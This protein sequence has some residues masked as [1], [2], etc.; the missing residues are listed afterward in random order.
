MKDYAEILNPARLSNGRAID[1]ALQVIEQDLTQ[2]NS[3]SIIEQILASGRARSIALLLSGVK[4]SAQLSSWILDDFPSNTSDYGGS[5]AAKL[6]SSLSEFSTFHLLLPDHREIALRLGAHYEEVTAASLAMQ[7]LATRELD[8]MKHQVTRQAPRIARSEKLC[9][10]FSDEE[11]ILRALMDLEISAPTHKSEV[12][13]VLA[14][15]L[16]RQKHSLRYYLE[17]LQVPQI[18]REIRTGIIQDSQQMQLP[19]PPNPPALSLV[20]DDGQETP[21][22]RLASEHTLER[23][24]KQVQLYEAIEGFGCWP[25]MISTRTSNDLREAR[26]RDRKNFLILLKKIRDLSRGDFSGDNQRRIN[27]AGDIIPVFEARATFK[28]RLIYQ[29][30]CRPETVTEERQVIRIFGVYTPAELNV[31]LWDAVGRQLAR[32]GKGYKDR[33]TYRRKL[34]SDSRLFVPATFPPLADKPVVESP[35]L[36][37]LHVPDDSDLQTILILQ[38]FVPFSRAL[39]NTIYADLDAIFPFEVS[40]EEKSIIEYPFS[41]YVLGRSGTGKTTAMLYKM[42]WVERS[43]QM[44]SEGMVKPRQLFVTQ[45]NV[46]AKKVQEYFNKT[47]ESVGM[48]AKSPLELKSVAKSRR[49]RENH[50]VLCDKD[51]DDDRHSPLPSKFSELQDEH[52]PC[53]ITFSRLCALLEADFEQGCNAVNASF[54]NDTQWTNRTKCVARKGVVSYNRFL[55]AYWCH[56]NQTLVKGLDSYSVFNELLGVIEGSEKAAFSAQKHMDLSAYESLSGRTNPTFSN[57]RKVICDIFRDYQKRKMEVGDYDA[58]DRSHSLIHHLREFGV[59]GRKLDYL[60]VDE[61]QDNLIIDA[62]LLRCLCNN[63]NGLF[64]AGDTA[65]TISSGCS[66]RF[67]DLKAMLYRMERQAEAN[68]SGRFR[69]TCELP[70]TFCLSVNY[71]SHSG[72][73]NCARSIVDLIHRYWP[74]SIDVLA[75][76]AGLIS[77]PLPIFLTECDKHDIRFGQFLFGASGDPLEFGAHQCILVRDVAAR[78]KLYE[79]VGD[80][81]IIMTIYESKGLEFNDVLLYNFFEDSALSMAQWR[82]IPNIGGFAPRFDEMKHVGLC[83]ELK[84]LY[85]AITRAKKNLW[86]TDFSEKAKPMKAFWSHNNLVHIQSADE[87]LP[88]LAESSTPEQWSVI[89]RTLFDR[90]QYTQAVYCFRRASLPREEAMANAYA[91]REGAE[92][93]PLGQPGS[94]AKIRRQNAYAAA[95]E[96]FLSCTSYDL[97]FSRRAGECF[98]ICGRY[99]EAAQ[100]HY[101]GENF[102]ESVSCY[103]KIGKFDEAVQIVLDK[104]NKVRPEMAERVRSAGRLF[105]LSKAETEKARQLFDSNK[106]LLEYCEDM[107]LDSARA[108]LLSSL[109]RYAEAAECFLEDGRPLDAIDLLLKD[110]CNMSST[111]KACSYAIQGLWKEMPFGARPDG[112][113]TLT[114][115]YLDILNRVN[116]NHLSPNDQSEIEMFG[117]IY[118]DDRPALLNLGKQ[119]FKFRN[120]TAAVRCLQLVYSELPPFQM[121]I[122]EELADALEVFQTY[123]Q[124]LSSIAFQHN[125]CN[126]PVAPQLFGFERRDEA[127]FLVPEHTIF[128]PAARSDASYVHKEVDG[129]VLVT[130]ERLN[131]VFKSVLGNQLKSLVSRENEL[132]LHS[133]ALQPCMYFVIYG[134]CRSSNCARDHPPKLDKR[135]YNYRICVHLLQIGILHSLTS[136]EAWHELIELRRTWI[137]RFYEAFHPPFYLLG[138]PSDIDLSIIPGSIHGLQKLKIWIRYLI[139]CLTFRSPQHFLTDFL[140]YAIISTSFDKAES[141]RYLYRSRYLSLQPTRGSHM[142]FPETN[143]LICAL[144]ALQGKR[145]DPWY[146]TK[147]IDFANY[148]V[149]KRLPIDIGVLCDFLE[150]LCGLSAIFVSRPYHQ[151]LLHDVLLPRSWWIKLTGHFDHNVDVGGVFLLLDTVSLLLNQLIS[152]DDT[153]YLLHGSWHLLKYGRTPFYWAHVTRLCRTMCLLGHNMKSVAMHN[154]I[155]ATFKHALTLDIRPPFMCKIYFGSYSWTGILAALHHTTFGLYQEE[156]LLICHKSK[157]IP[158][159]GKER[160]FRRIT[161]VNEPQLQTLI[162]SSQ[163]TLNEQPDPGDLQKTVNQDIK[164]KEPSTHEVMLQATE[165]EQAGYETAEYEVVQEDDEDKKVDNDHEDATEAAS[166]RLE[167]AVLT[168]EESSAGSIIRK[169]YRKYSRRKKAPVMRIFRTFLEHSEAMQWTPRSLYRRLYLG[170]LPHLLM[171]LENIN[172]EIFSRKTYAKGMLKNGLGPQEVDKASIMLNE[173]STHTKAVRRF[174]EVLGPTAT[175]HQDRDREQLKSLVQ[176]AASFIK[177]IERLPSSVRQAVEED[178]EIAVK[179]IVREKVPKAKKK[180]ELNLEDDLETLEYVYP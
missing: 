7:A 139:D 132:C 73:V 119:F 173:I 131:V 153:V 123:I 89:G 97:V 172:A 88:Q 101:C 129:G 44:N 156:L 66:F 170:P 72:I 150:F 6:L 50:D 1:D 151:G 108:I 90:K 5:T 60:Y 55:S 27:Q 21:Q 61:A 107:G 54:Q 141:H 36:D 59:P 34:G 91:L 115:R 46:L 43:F 99:L 57:N 167:Y 81:G 86:I 12:D 144:Q 98:E 2:V 100:A 112:S 163:S 74:H 14:Q 33:C 105:Y 138:T 149:N 142:L 180:P 160:F 134:R 137:Y 145:N 154:K 140:R 53:F 42:L 133:R 95:A 124:S 19:N 116:K 176:E 106:D 171:C 85:V 87:E 136:L 122:I 31:K 17:V 64:W 159:M 30:D 125:P 70:K 177:G 103:R 9:P 37:L 127:L 157:S 40:L 58:A 178:L 169:A 45:S 175:V 22:N 147:G 114:L 69:A 92:R 79:K 179:G 25:V 78:D 67:Q 174:K 39:L 3:A 135:W 93:L 161:Y 41:C 130:C 49:S 117:A 35:I 148:I 24:L 111:K 4:S 29:I 84:S 16:D 121:M 80:I 128:Y 38:K 104:G 109:G 63:P 143:V 152:A 165:K 51:E 26:R 65:Q 56:F 120:E 96:A 94:S 18:G 23:P 76:E 126:T 164:T 32:K 8:E 77:G 20:A 11:P 158:G 52:F 102:T 118:R 162:K 155:L 146:L 62:L 48:A 28:L 75:P 83:A 82:L 166:T 13:S 71:R 113:S 47:L 68:H 10:M 110:S 15:L 168:E